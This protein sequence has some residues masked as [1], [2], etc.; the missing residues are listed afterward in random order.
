[1]L[2][3]DSSL[4]KSMISQRMGR[5]SDTVIMS[6]NLTKL[7]WM[8]PY[9]AMRTDSILRERRLTARALDRV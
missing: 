7:R 4:E 1:M 6:A 5:V 9:A 8:L 2:L 3:A